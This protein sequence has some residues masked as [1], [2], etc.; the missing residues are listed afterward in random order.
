MEGKKVISYKNMPSQLPWTLTAIVW[1]LLDRFQAS[2]V[3]IAVAWTVIVLLWI[4]ALINIIKEETV[5]IFE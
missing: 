3:V 2:D 1:L 5:D 4:G